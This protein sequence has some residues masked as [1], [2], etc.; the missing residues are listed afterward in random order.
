[1]GIKPEHNCEM[2]KTEAANRDSCDVGKIKQFAMFA[3]PIHINGIRF[4]NGSYPSSNVLDVSSAEL[5][6]SDNSYVGIN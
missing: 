3:F 1:M 6:R 2:H 4:D 5:R